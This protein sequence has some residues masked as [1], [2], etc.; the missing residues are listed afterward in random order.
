MWAEGQPYHNLPHLPPGGGGRSAG[1]DPLALPSLATSN[2]STG[3]SKQNLYFIFVNFR[4]NLMELK[5]SIFLGGFYW[6]VFSYKIVSYKIEQILYRFW[7][8]FL[9]VDLEYVL[10]FIFV[11]FFLSSSGTDG[12]AAA[13]GRWGSPAP[14]PSGSKA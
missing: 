8:N 5:F 11:F 4:V 6:R 1:V 9:Y 2:S 12:A 7:I 10:D 13:A 14:A 3:K